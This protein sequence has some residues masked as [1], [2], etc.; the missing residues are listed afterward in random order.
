[1]KYKGNMMNDYNMIQGI[2]MV[3]IS[4]GSFM[5]GHDISMIHH[6]LKRLINTIPMNN[7]FTE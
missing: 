4:A 6:C 7:P 2:K 3:V 1:M 5:M